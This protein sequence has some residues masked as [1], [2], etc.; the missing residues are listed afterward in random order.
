MN[1]AVSDKI[2]TV[3]APSEVEVDWKS[4]TTIAALGSLISTITTGYVFGFK[5]NLFHLPIVFSLYD[6]PQFAG[7]QF[8]QSLRYFAAGP[9]LL[10]RGMG[11]HVDAYW[12]FMILHLL[13]RFIAFVGLLACADLLGVRKRTDRLFLTALLCATPLLRG[14]SLAGGGG[15]FINVFAHSEI[16]I[17]LT[18]LAIYFLIRGKIAVGV[19]F[20]GLV[21][22]VNAFVGVW[23]AVVYV[24]VISVMLL[25]RAIPLRKTVF[26]IAVG[27]V[28]AGLLAAPVFWNIATNPEIGTPLGFDYVSF[29]EEYWPY[30]FLFEDVEAFQ[31]LGLLSL[32][33][34]GLAAFI[35]LGKDGRLFLVAMV[36]YVAVY[37]FG[38]IVPY[39]THSPAVLNLH[40]LRVGVMLHLLAALGTLVLATKWWMNPDPIFA[41]VFSPALILLTC[42][43]MKMSSIQPTINLT[44]AGLLIAGS[45]SPY[46]HSII[47][48]WVVR[49]RFRLRHFAV[50]LVTLGLLIVLTRNI[51]LNERSASWIAEWKTLGLWAKAET[52]PNAV[53]LFPTWNLRGNSRA[54]PLDVVE[55]E[56]MSNSA[57]FEAMAHRSVFADFRR[58]A[59]IMWWPSY[60]QQWHQR[61][62]EAISLDTYGSKIAYA[63]SNGISYLV[64]VCERHI[65]AEPAFTTKR[66]CVYSVN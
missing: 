6:E 17:G 37:C 20:N 62:T 58:G 47:P 36:A 40:L 18:L 26:E 33:A 31:K 11:N 15:L 43:P 57:I 27:T 2:S 49:G 52:P 23:N 21:I 5:N 24:A 28:I 61:V 60:Y 7:D 63:K 42:T 45:S 65:A 30:H 22:F 13:T 66:L 25:Q 14:D 19:A 50:F 64:E 55:D 44:L 39:F 35:Q 9:W 1:T 16:D 51:I 41:R 56:A 38:I 12:L 54:S 4:L 10:L 3:R 34:M 29:L 32:T 59:A 46:V 8:I 48:Q 53:F